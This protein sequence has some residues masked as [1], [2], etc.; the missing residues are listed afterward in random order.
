MHSTVDHQPVVKRL[1]DFDTRSGNL[2]ERT[3]FNNR[4]LIV[5]LCVVGTLLLGWQATRIQLN[6]SFEKMIPTG[7]P[8]IANFLASRRG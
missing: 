3:L 2:A 5:V 8:Y 7:H 4:L 1:E 6:A